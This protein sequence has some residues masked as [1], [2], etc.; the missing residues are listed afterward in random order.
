MSLAAAHQASLWISRRNNVV[1]PAQRFGL[2]ALPD[3][4]VL[5]LLGTQSN[6]VGKDLE[7]SCTS[8]IQPLPKVSTHLQTP[9]DEAD[10]HGVRQCRALGTNV[11][12]HDSD[13]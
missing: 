8:T 2:L 9:V 13:T 5:D 12:S 1:H 7:T 3:K 11:D 6:V 4:N 10:L